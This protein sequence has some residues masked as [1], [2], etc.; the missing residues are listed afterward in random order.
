MYRG[1]VSTVFVGSGITFT[2]YRV[3]FTFKN[4]KED[5]QKPL[6][7]SQ[8]VRMKESGFCVHQKLLKMTSGQKAFS[9]RGAKLWNSLKRADKLAPSLKT[10]KEQ[11]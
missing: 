4:G 6:Y 9:Y 7:H 8:N 11:L 1:A 3:M 10:F 2:F 5:L